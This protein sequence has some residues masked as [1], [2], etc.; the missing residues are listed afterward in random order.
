MKQRALLLL[1][2][3]YLLAGRSLTSPGQQP[4]L[5]VQTGHSSE[6][7]NVWLSPDE[8]SLVS[9]SDEKLIFWNLQDRTIRR[10]VKDVE[11]FH[12]SPNNKYVAAREKNRTRLSIWEL[13]TGNSLFTIPA[14][15]DWNFSSSGGLI[16]SGHPLGVVRIW[17][18]KELKV[19]ET[20]LPHQELVNDCILREEGLLAVCATDA[21]QGTVY[22]TDFKAKDD[23]RQIEEIGSW[24]VTPDGRF[25]ITL[26]RGG[27]LAGRELNK[28]PGEVVAAQTFSEEGV[29][30][31][32]LSPRGRYLFAYG[33]NRQKNILETATG[34]AAF[35]FIREGGV[36]FSDD[37]KILRVG[38]RSYSVEDGRFLPE[39]EIPGRYERLFSPNGNMLFLYELDSP[40]SLWDVTQGRAVLSKPRAPYNAYDYRIDRTSYPYPTTFSPSGKFLVIRERKYVS[41]I[42]EQIRV[43]LWDAQ[44]GEKTQVFESHKPALQPT[45]G[46]GAGGD[47]RRGTYVPIKL[48]TPNQHAAEEKLVFNRKE[49]LLVASDGTGNIHLWDIS[50][51][52]RLS[53]LKSHSSA[54]MAFI[55]TK[56]EGLNVFDTRTSYRFWDFGS[57]NISD[58]LD[59]SLQYNAKGE[60]SE[61]SEG[62]TYTLKNARTGKI[63][64]REES[65]THCGLSENTEI[66]VCYRMTPGVRPGQNANCFD[67]MVRSVKTKE[68]LFARS[69]TASGNVSPDG[70]YVWVH[71]KAGE[72][73]RVE[74]FDL[75]TKRAVLTRDGLDNWD[76]EFSPSGKHLAFITKTA[77]ETYQIDIWD[78]TKGVSVFTQGGIWYSHSFSPSGKYLRI[79]RKAGAQTQVEVWDVEAN[80][81]KL[82]VVQEKPYGG[83]NYWNVGFSGDGKSIVLAHDTGSMS[84]GGKSF[85][86]Y[87]LESW[88]IESRTRTFVAE[89]I[90]YHDFNGDWSQLLVEF[91][92]RLKWWDFK[93][94]ATKEVKL[95]PATSPRRNVGLHTSRVSSK[96]NYRAFW[97]RK[98]MR[99]SSTVLLWDTVKNRIHRLEG[100]SSVITSANFSDDERYVL[101]SSEDG[102]IKLWLADGGRLLLTFVLL[103][104]N[105][106]LVTTPEGFFDGT[107]DAW[108]QLVWRLGENAT[109]PVELYFNDFFYPNLLQDVL[110]GKPPKAPAGAEL[111]EKDRRQPRVSIVSVNGQT[112]AQLDARPDDAPMIDRRTATVSIEVADNPEPRKQLAHRETSGAQDL[113]LFRN[114]SLVKVWHDDVFKLGPRDGC[115]QV[116]QPA[117]P[118]RVRCTATVPIVADANSFTAYAFNSSNVKSND[119]SVS[120]R[121]TESL[122]RDGVLYVLAV[123]VNKYANAD[124]NLTFAV[125]D[126]RDI[127]A[128]IKAEQKRLAADAGL[129]QYA[130]TAIVT[131]V[132][133]HA[134]K[135]NIL[136]ALRRFSEGEDARVP[137][138]AQGRLKTELSKIKP[139]Q[140]EDALIIYYAGH[141]TSQGRRFYL[142]PHNFTGAGRDALE[143]QGVSDVELDGVLERVDAGRML[144]VIDACQSG[145][146]LGRANEGRAPMNSKGLAQLAYDKG[147]LILTAAQSQQAALEAVRIGLK[148][149]RHGLLTYALLQGLAGGAADRDGNGQLWEREWLDYAVAQVP[150]LQMEAMKQR[151][152]E[153]EKTGRGAELLYFNGDDKSS[154]PDAR[155]VQTPRVFYRRE[156]QSNPMIVAKP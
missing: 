77:A 45:M 145:Q 79:N 119:D 19:Y 4:Q 126:V 98:G 92:D 20:R 81:N 48:N 64:L 53:T 107:P 91:D 82:K 63:I 10:E 6:V 27:R 85:S 26:D 105:G 65:V 61:I 131:L 155:K 3:L 111:G 23:W 108:K 102:T 121:G 124:Y 88:D 72:K 55:T 112:R 120:V 87:T 67:L 135:E 146:V 31:W 42:D 44:T 40:R 12:V 80:L 84:A 25:L 11:K 149:I 129:R 130:R 33:E 22:L 133:E 97:E 109:S 9:L 150:L 89:D 28:S 47:G 140:P 36:E 57:G 95:T 139:A 35:T 106:W 156:A 59:Y 1:C 15:V 136:L 8:K 49:T 113:R 52:K 38:A 46:F 39:F 117:G 110:A 54:T 30:V 73:F 153:I 74:V 50:N 134:T 103:N 154:S 114:G 132:N 115:E 76:R 5:V 62:R 24:G 137:A 13:E 68:V 99:E 69:G 143:S 94:G 104:E 29:S 90:S 75:R 96:N 152:L 141:G 56:A 14:F 32:R 147:M 34:R 21:N 118:R 58:S 83:E 70:A 18:I 66:L 17:D 127:G 16:I 148:E 2:L 86:K 101:T 37:E 100:H 7:K 51:R 138:D 125:P 116:A 60:Y 142:L 123:G 128:A 43:T 122:K 93:S 151:H 78:L 41:S 144:M 71:E